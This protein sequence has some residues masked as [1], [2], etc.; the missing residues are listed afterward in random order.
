MDK[1]KQG[2]AMEIISWEY[3]GQVF[4][5]FKCEELIKIDFFSWCCGMVKKVGQIFKQDECWRLRIF[6]A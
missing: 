6:L 5:S 2:K 3:F 4:I 1:S